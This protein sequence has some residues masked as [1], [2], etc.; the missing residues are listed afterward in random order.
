[1]NFYFQT[2]GL[3]WLARQFACQFWKI[4]LVLC[5]AGCAQ[6]PAVM[7]GPLTIAKQGSFFIGGRDLHSDTLSTLPAYA[8]S[9]TITVEQMYVHYQIPVDVKRPP[10]TLIHGFPQDW[11]E[12]R[13]I[14]PRLAKRFTVIA[15]D[16]RGIGGSKATKGEYDAVAMAEDSIS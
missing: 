10:I 2:R 13:A 11:F 6:Q 9:G 15:V 5:V 7:D 3:A 14:M 4:G 12:Y 8:P 16:L 1:M